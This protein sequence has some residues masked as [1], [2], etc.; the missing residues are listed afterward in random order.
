MTRDAYA[1]YFADLIADLTQSAVALNADGRGPKRVNFSVALTEQGL[2]IT[3]PWEPEDPIDKC[4]PPPTHIPIEI[5]KVPL[6]TPAGDVVLGKTRRGRTVKAHQLIDA[7]R[8]GWPGFKALC[9]KT[10][11]DTHNDG[12]SSWL[13]KCVALGLLVKDGKGYAVAPTHEDAA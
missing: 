12:L 5:L 11:F 1:E 3:L 4:E 2:L 9:A 13:K 7:I 6:G 10:S 8:D